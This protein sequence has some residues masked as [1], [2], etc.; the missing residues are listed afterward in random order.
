[1][2]K[3]ITAVTLTALM[4]L[5]MFTAMV[6]SASA[7]EEVSAPYEFMAA[8]VDVTNGAWL[9]LSSYNNPSLLYFDI[10]EGE[11]NE[12]LNMYIGDDLNIDDG[13]FTYNTTI[14]EAEGGPHVAWMGAA[15]YVVTND[16]GEW[17]ISEKLLDE[18]EDDDYLLRVA[19]SKILPEGFAISV[20]EID[21]DGEEAWISVTQD[22]EEIGSEVVSTAEG[23]DPNFVYKYDLDDDGTKDEIL[24]F[25][26]E[27]VFAGM[28][29][30][31]VKINNIDLIS[32]NPI[33]IENNDDDL[34]QDFVVK[35]TNDPTLE[36]ELDSG[37]EIG[38]SKD[39]VTQ[40]FA[41]RVSIRI[42]DDGDYAAAVKIITEPGTYELM[43]A[44]ANV[45]DGAW[46][47][48]SSFNN[49]SLLFYDIDE[50]EGNE[51]LN[52]YIGDD[53]NIDDGNF[54]YNTTIYEAEGGPHVAWMGA[55]YYVV[56]NDTGEWWI[57]EKLLDEDEDDDYL[58]RVAESKIL[59]EGFAISVLEI[60]VDGEEAWISVTQDGEEI[61]SEVVSTAEGKDPNFVY[62][63]DLDDDGTKDE[64]LN[65][66]VETVFAGMNTN[67]VKINNID[68]I[69]MNP[70]EIENNDDDLFQD[71]V[72]K[73]T[74]DPTLEIELD[75]GEEIGLSQDSITE[76]FADRV[77]IRINDD[78]DYA[79][80]VKEVIVGGVA[81]ATP[82]E[83]LTV[84]PTVEPTEVATGDGTAA[85]TAVVTAV[86]T[87]TPTPTPTKEPGFE[88]VFAIAG[89]LA[90]AYLVLRQRE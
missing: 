45:T 85:P 1:M 87:E 75:S 62:K 37:E 76:V 89:L 77:S 69:S 18:D 68:L 21:V 70:I 42:N 11:G 28:N 60:D 35:L 41:D 30:N 10:D 34:F 52:M 59:P 15:Y 5:T 4:V 17:W 39:S 38:L 61:G 65:F 33:E 66:T 57:S 3:K 29:T 25:T 32:M 27:T 78:G 2:N 24:N 86:V 67:L 48:L 51:N 63:Y 43:G 7:V 26:V 71:F 9:N 19:E 6:P 50:G 31:L 64:I 58:L 14:Y 12:N 20:L 53:L 84:E 44:V 13:N 49:P 83:D 82:T 80:A 81:V 79:A 90:V 46:L 16:T 54:T 56:T 74:N 55:A 22:G 88:A 36:I 23:K 72:V 8:V 47:N 73:L 40:V